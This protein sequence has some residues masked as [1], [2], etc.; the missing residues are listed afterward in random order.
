MEGFVRHFV[1]PILRRRHWKSILEIG[2]S[3][4]RST[5]ALRRHP[6]SSYT[7][8]DPCLD[9]D[10][11]AKYASDPLVQVLRCNSLDALTVDG[12]LRDGSTFDCILID[13]DH[14]WYT[15]FNELRLIRERNLLRRGGYIFLHDVGWPYGRRDMYYQPDSIPAE[16]RRPFSD[17]GVIRGQSELSE[18]GSF[19]RILMKATEE[20]GPRN[21][22]LTAVEDFLAQ[23]PHEY[24][25]CRVRMQYG[26]GIVQ[27]RSGGLLS[28]ISFTW[29]RMKALAYSILGQPA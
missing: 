7:I 17:K 28:S 11:Q 13:G 10:L 6:L 23:H 22:V 3:T 29:L 9:K 25:F 5:D 16:F 4:G 1:V 12:A 21:G 14:N 2:A 8:I 27:L 18:A 15:V 19:N 26:L 20:G 24:R